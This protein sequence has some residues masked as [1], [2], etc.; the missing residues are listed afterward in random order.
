MH[1]K[2]KMDKLGGHGEESLTVSNCRGG[3]QRDV[4]IMKSIVMGN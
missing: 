2:G 1:P 4:G 3:M